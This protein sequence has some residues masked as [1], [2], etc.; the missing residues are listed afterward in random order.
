MYSIKKQGA[1][2]VI[3][4][5]VALDLNNAES[6][7]DFSYKA[8]QDGQPRIIFDMSEVPLID[9]A[10]MDA[11]MDLQDECMRRGG[12]LRISSP[13]NLCQDIL[14]VCEVSKSIEVLSDTTQ[15]VGRFS[16]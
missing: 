5:E 1:V 10:G 16:L 11:I 8:L 3:H 15:A 4:S 14:D 13:T 9:S 12:S 6:F 7:R 2:D